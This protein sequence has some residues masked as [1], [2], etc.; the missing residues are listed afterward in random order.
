MCAY[1]F[2]KSCP[3]KLSN[4]PTCPKHHNTNGFS[5]W[6][7]VHILSKWTLCCPTVHFLRKSSAHSVCNSGGD[8]NAK[9]DDGIS[10]IIFAHPNGGTDF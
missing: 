5:D 4:C 10:T 6:T 8:W 1:I 3:K 9:I 2:L 7:T